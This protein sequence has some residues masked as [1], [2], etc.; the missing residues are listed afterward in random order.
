MAIIELCSIEAKQ[1]YRISQAVDD[2]EGEVF[3]Y[4]TEKSQCLERIC[5][6]PNRNLTLELHAGKDKDGPV[7][8]EMEKPFHL[9]GCCICRPQFNVF[10]G[11]EKAAQIGTIFDPCTCCIINQ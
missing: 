6:G 10:M 3:L 1:R 11:N 9:Q 2:K 4:I 7:I 5:C 8:Q